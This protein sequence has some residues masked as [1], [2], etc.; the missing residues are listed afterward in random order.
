MKH[1]INDFEG[2]LDLLLHL[3]KTSKMSIYDVDIKIIINDYLKFIDNVDKSRLDDISEYLVYA[4]ELIHLKSRLLINKNIVSDDEVSD[5]LFINEETLKEKLKEYEKYK[6]LSISMK[7]KEML[8]KEL[9]TNSPYSL[10]EFSSKRVLEDNASLD[11][12]LVAFQKMNERRNFNK[13]L[14]TKITKKELSVEDK[15]SEISM[16]LDENFT[17]NFT[18]LFTENTKE[19]LVV[20]FLAILTMQK[21]NLLK[22]IQKNNFSEI[23]LEKN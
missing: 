20:T 9:F 1:T 15:I 3:I 12:L 13:P 19:E 8:R 16:I 11:D 23:T 5:S 2:P 7:E 4:S 14:S 18:S 22:I 17:V 10:K 21:D 6:K